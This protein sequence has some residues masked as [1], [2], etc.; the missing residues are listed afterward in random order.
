MTLNPRIIATTRADGREVLHLGT[1]F[2][3]AAPINLPS[4]VYKGITVPPNGWLQQWTIRP[5]P[6]AVIRSPAQIVA[7]N[8]MFPFGDTGCRVDAPPLRIPFSKPMDSSG[9]TKYMPSTGERRDI[10]LVT[11]PAAYFMLGGSADDLIDW[12]LAA[13]SCPLHFRDETTGKPIDLL[14]YQQ[15]NIADSKGGQGEPWLDKGPPIPASGTVYLAD[16]VTLDKNAPGYSSGSNGYSAFADNW[17]VQQAHFPELSYMAHLATGDLGFLEDLQYE[18][19]LVVVANASMSTPAGAVVSGEYRG[20]AWAFRQLFMAHIAT[21]DAEAAGTLP[22]ECHPSSYFKKLLD[23]TLA[24]WS[25]CITD[26]NNQVFRLIFDNGSM[27]PW[28]CDY[29][30][31]AL[32][33][34]VLTGHADWA[35][36]YLF[37]LG[38]AVARTNGTSGYLVGYGGAYYM[39]TYPHGDTS[40]PRYTSWA[41]SFAELAD[42]TAPNTD[43]SYTDAIIA[44]LKADQFNGGKAFT[45]QGYLMSARA[46]LVMA[47]YLD[48]KGL[49][50]VRQ[51]YPDLDVCI[52]NVQKMHLAYGSV[53]PRTSVIDPLLPII[54]PPTGEITVSDIAFNAPF[55]ATASFKDNK[56][57][58]M[59]PDTVSWDAPAAFKI[60]ADPTDKLK[61]HGVYGAEGSN[62]I[63]ATGVKDGISVPATKEVTVP[64]AIPFL[65]TG[66][67][68]L[69]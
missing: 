63:T 22:A 68:E 48:K 56:G 13:G 3:G 51:A 39:S 52:A 40:K 4:Y 5:K 53:S 14:K 58:A 18:A 64:A 69:S 7:A 37:L 50:N 42:P 25:K 9:V 23:Q 10:G 27:G 57:N 12:A 15:A 6:V 2:D 36:L 11:D 41:Q 26:P 61:A 33:F 54:Q 49:A 65:A 31:T 20:M 24:Y 29:M 66:S 19:N 30:L 60:T 17:T 34:G 46:V 43:P 45:G 16:G 8:R 28:L 44:K 47:S 62:N 67:I 32:A 55:T 59:V 35:P 1:L 38:N 21:K